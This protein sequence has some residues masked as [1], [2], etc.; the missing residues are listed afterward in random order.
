MHA[1][2][3]RLGIHPNVQSF[4]EPHYHSDSKGNL[5]FDYGS[6]L[7]TYGLAFH[8][9]P[10][11]Q[12]CWIAGEQKFARQVIICSSAM[13]AIA[14]LNCNSRHQQRMETLLFIAT[15]SQLNAEKLQKFRQR[16]PQRKYGLLFSDDLLGRVCDLKIAA[17]LAGCPAEV[18]IFDNN[19]HINFR[20]RSFQMDCETFSLHA[21]DRLCGF[22]FNIPTRKPKGHTSWLSQLEALSFNL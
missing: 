19:V 1:Y 12:G 20:N 11:T 8:R 21:F 17:A 15:G 5:C 22:R 18:S 16:F 7:E 3:T 2:L 6:D 14:W 13:E 4:F 10:L 9:V